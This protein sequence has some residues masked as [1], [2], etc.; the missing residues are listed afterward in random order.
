MMGR[1]DVSSEKKVI[2]HN[3]SMSGQRQIYFFDGKFSFLLNFDNEWMYILSMQLAPYNKTNDQCL[4][5]EQITY[6][7]TKI[8][9]LE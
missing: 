4:P 8:R 5:S 3:R 9:L 1:R 7:K 2:D 6:D